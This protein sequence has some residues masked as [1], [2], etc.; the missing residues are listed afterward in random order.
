M[1]DFSTG[2]SWK[3]RIMTKDAHMDAEPA[4]AEDTAIM[5][6][7]FGGKTTWT[8]KAVWVT[9]SS[10][11]MP[12]AIRRP[13]TR[14][15]RPR[16]SSNIDGFAKLDRNRIIWDFSYSSICKKSHSLLRGKNG[17]F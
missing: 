14:A 10:A 8:P 15:G 16:R 7:A 9:F 3:L 6:K 17:F 13:S 1:Y 2:Y 12:R 4:T 11:R 5:L